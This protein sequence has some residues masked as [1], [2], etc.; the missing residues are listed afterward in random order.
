[1][2][3]KPDLLTAEDAKGLNAPETARLFSRHMNPGQ[4]HFLKLLGFDKVIV[5]RA[6]GMYYE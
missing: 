5:D 6:D 1:M 2:I 3:A 4:L